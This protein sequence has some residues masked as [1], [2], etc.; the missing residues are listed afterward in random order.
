MGKTL[1]LEVNYILSFTAELQVLYH[2]IN[3]VERQPLTTR[4]YPLVLS[5]KTFQQ[6]YFIIPRESDFLDIVDT[7][8]KFAQPS[9]RVGT[10]VCVCACAI[11]LYRAIQ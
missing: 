10:N 1:P 9:M 7:I 5:C 2:H 6:L 8:H 11:F 4:G 3:G